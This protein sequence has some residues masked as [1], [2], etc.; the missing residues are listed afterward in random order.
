[1]PPHG[2][3][4][5]PTGGTPLMRIHHKD[6]VSTD[7]TE[8]P[9]CSVD[10]LFIC[11]TQRSA[12][13]TKTTSHGHDSRRLITHCTTSCADTREHRST[14]AQP[15]VVIHTFIHSYIHTFIVKSTYPTTEKWLR[16]LYLQHEQHQHE[17]ITST[18]MTRTITTRASCT[19]EHG[20]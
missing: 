4:G 13:D 19:S 14:L 6:G 16:K 17:R 18:R 11:G 10:Q 20:T 7:R 1:M 9:V 8:K 5:K 2:G 12:P 15:V 3:N